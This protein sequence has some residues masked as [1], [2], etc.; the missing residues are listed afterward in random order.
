MHSYSEGIIAILSLSHSLSLFLSLSLPS[1]PLTYR[2][3]PTITGFS[4]F[5]NT[6]TTPSSTN[7]LHNNNTITTLN[8]REGLTVVG[9]FPRQRLRSGPLVPAKPELSSFLLHCDQLVAGGNLTEKKEYKE[10]EREKEGG[11]YLDT[12]FIIQPPLVS[13][14]LQSN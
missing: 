6:I 1:S 3:T 13:G 14:Q 12:A 11:D 4:W 7:N 9:L 2:Y 10:I 5:L 8:K